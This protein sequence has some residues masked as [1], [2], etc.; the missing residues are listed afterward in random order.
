[1]SR[2]LAISICVCTYNRADML[3]ATLPALAALRHDPAALSLELVLVDNNSADG[4]RAAVETLRGRF[5][6]PVRYVFEGRQGLSHARNAAIEAAA[7]D[8]LA[9]LDDE[10]IVRPDWAEVAARTIA[11]SGAAI[12]GGPY[13]AGFLDGPRP[14][15]FATKYG[16]AHFLDRPRV[17]RGFVERFNVTGGN[18]L[19]R[20]DVFDG[21]RFDPAFGMSGDRI[22]V[23]EEVVLQQ[24]WLDAHPGEAVWYEPALAVTHLVRPDKMSL[25]Y[26]LR[27]ELALGRAAAARIRAGRRRNHIDG[28]TV[29]RDVLDL[30]LSPWRAWRRDRARYP[31]WQNFYY[32]EVLPG[33]VRRLACARA[34]RRGG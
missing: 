21:L 14:H 28:A 2:P 11:E 32:E 8:Y 18:M 12:V 19:L 1:V 5:P 10:C 17:V 33:P 23:S 30:V 13:F 20:R 34:V 7:G 6:Y 26:K 24:A 22:G 15:W 27:R 3:A 4:T 16:D 31:Y 29:R 25:R 9:F